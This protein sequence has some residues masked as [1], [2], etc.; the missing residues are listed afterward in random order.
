MIP[1]SVT[2]LEK[3][4]LTPNGKIDRQALPSP[5]E[6]VVARTEANL[7]PQTAAER[8]IATI[9][10]QV[11]RVTNVGIHSNFFDLGGHSLLLLRVQTKLQDHFARP[12]ALTDLFEYPTIHSLAQYLTSPSE[13][14]VTTPAPDTQADR[15]RHWEG[16]RTQRRSLRQQHRSNT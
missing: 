13:E 11:L 7:L 4:P 3:L 8:T 2:V 12:I 16:A 10:Q 9:W 15:R 6:T 5:D 1:A 14:T